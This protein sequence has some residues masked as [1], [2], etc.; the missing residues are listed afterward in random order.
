[1]DRHDTFQILEIVKFAVFTVCHW[2]FPLTPVS[3]N[4]FKATVYH[5]CNKINKLGVFRSV[6]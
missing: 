4:I 2:L 1:M 5:F 6:A 3:I